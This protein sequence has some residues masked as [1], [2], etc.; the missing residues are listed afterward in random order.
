MRTTIDDRRTPDSAVQAGSSAVAPGASA[1]TRGIRPV[2]YLVF[3]GAVLVSLTVL[4]WAPAPFF[5]LWINWAVTLFVAVFCVRGAWL[6][7]FFVNAGIVAILLA[8][9]EA[10]LY[11]HE[12]T[13][14][15]YPDG[16]YFVSDD[17]LGWKPT[18]GVHA[19]AI[20]PLPASLFHHPRGRLFDVVYTIDSNGL[21]VAPPYRKD[22]LAGT[23]L[24]FGCSFTF[25][26][27]LKDDETL[28]Y[29]VG[30]Q[31]GGRY[32]IFNFA[33]QAYNPA[34]MLGSIEHGL[35]SQVVDTLPQYAYYVALPTHVSRVAG[36]VSWGW[37]APRYVLDARGN[38]IQD[39]NFETREP[40]ALR[41]GLGHHIAAQLEKSAIWRA[42]S[43]HDSPVTDDDFQLY[44][45]VVRRS[46]LLLKQQYPDLQFRVLLWPPVL[47]QEW[48]IY[49]RLQDGFRRMNIPLDLAVDA[50]PHYNTHPI[51]YWLSD[52]DRHPNALANR[53]LAADV[54]SKLGK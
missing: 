21:R 1:A 34:Q 20:K 40:L 15:I 37:H 25:G 33:V 50:L 45:A 38:P 6:R 3:L 14:P 4:K 2:L 9:A 10:Y 19:H 27:G 28:P 31:S 26:E 36:R 29:Q 49:Q 44:F 41:L 47:P 42:I 18:K 11:T 17:V 12:Y 30:I 54:L 16:A 53:L 51:E 8:T 39:G 24:F 13:V 5:W 48:P 7:A 32:R 23:V 52:T 43:S 22:D 35:V 46:Q